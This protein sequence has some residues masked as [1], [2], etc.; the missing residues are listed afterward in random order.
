MT[1][2]NKN[3]I[4]ELGNEETSF[5]ESHRGIEKGVNKVSYR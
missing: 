4:T 1:I 5:E 3:K 2:N